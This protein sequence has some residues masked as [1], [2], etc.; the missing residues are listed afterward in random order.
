MIAARR[1]SICGHGD[2]ASIRS[3]GRQKPSDERSWRSCPDVLTIKEPLPSSAG[4]QFRPC[5]ENVSLC[6][7]SR[8][9]IAAARLPLPALPGG[10]LWQRCV[11]SFSTVWLPR[12]R[13][14]IMAVRVARRPRR[15]PGDFVAPED[16]GC[17]PLRLSVL[18]GWGA[19]RSSNGAPGVA[20]KLGRSG[21]ALFYRKARGRTGADVV[22]TNTGVKEGAAR[23]PGKWPVG[24]I[25]TASA[26]NEW[27]R[28]RS[29]HV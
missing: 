25:L 28:C 13:A 12:G 7:E 22:R 29:V 4:P 8:N 3:V 24:G 19:A 26:A 2:I 11:V 14:G 10:S 6:V 15:G 16:W 27:E 18:G 21:Q 20:V 1:V 17:P 23:G 5:G 9:R